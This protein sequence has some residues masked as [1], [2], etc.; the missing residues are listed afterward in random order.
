MVLGTNSMQDVIELTSV[1][2]KFLVK[3]SDAKP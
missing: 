3:M 2:M 1:I